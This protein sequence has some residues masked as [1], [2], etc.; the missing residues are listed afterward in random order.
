MNG[1]TQKNSV[2][3]IHV[4]QR[5]EMRVSG[6]RE[7]ISFD[8]GSVSLR[9]DCGELTVEGSDLRVGALDTDSG[10]VVLTGR[11]DTLYY[12]DD[13]QEEKRGFFGRLFR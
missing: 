2:H 11:I 8:E 6:V 7:V 13:R 12:S 3:E 4:G 1:Q 10:V 9:S 5:K